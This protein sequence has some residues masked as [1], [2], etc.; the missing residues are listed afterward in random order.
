MNA[1]KHI[2][3]T[4]V[5]PRLNTLTA[6][7]ISAFRGLVTNTSAREPLEIAGDGFCESPYVLPG[8]KQ[9]R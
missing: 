5:V 8:T 1:M 9:Q 2:M 6:W 3:R 7:Q 4:V